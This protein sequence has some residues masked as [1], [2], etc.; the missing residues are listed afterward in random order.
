MYD[1]IKT[2]VESDEVLLY[3]S[4][5]VFYAIMPVCFSANKDKQFRLSMQNEN[6]HH[7]KPLLQISSIQNIFYT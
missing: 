3:V 4:T 7:K 2:K 6:E 5:C 1:K